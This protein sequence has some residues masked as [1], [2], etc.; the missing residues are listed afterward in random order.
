MTGKGAGPK[1][2]GKHGLAR[3]ESAIGHSFGKIEL[4]RQALTHSSH[5]NESP[6]GSEGPHAINKYGSDNEQFEFLG[7]SI[8]AFVTSQALFE[9]YPHYSE[10]QLS[11][12]RAHLVSARHLV[13]VANQLNLSTFLR[14]G[15]GEERSGGRQKPALLVNALEAILAAIYLDGGLD[16]ARKLILARIVYPE[17]ERME[18]D[19]ENSLAL[20]DQ[21]SALQE[22]LQSVGGP[23]PVYQVVSEDGPDHDKTFTVELRIVN[24]TAE[25]KLME[26]YV[27]RAQGT[28]KKKAEQRA[29][30]DALI[31]LRSRHRSI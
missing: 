4:L 9:R 14:L 16:P 21:K 23:S 7:D 10:G 11:K 13:A 15:K 27:S 20:S 25:S 30:Q 22:W 24:G 28:T 3:L 1:A 12:T 17:L 6:D 31:T 29:A 8:L 18:K 19:P 2:D 26:P 5:A